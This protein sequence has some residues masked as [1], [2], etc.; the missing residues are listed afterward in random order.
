MGLFGRLK[1][2]FQGKKGN[3]IFKD[4][5]DISELRKFT[6][7]ETLSKK[8]QDNIALIKEYQGNSFGLQVRE[9]QMGPKNVQGAA[10]F[11]EGMVSTNILDQV[12]HALL[13]ESAKFADLPAKGSE[14]LPFVRDKLIPAPEV[15]GVEGLNELFDKLLLG[16]T[17]FLFDGTDK[18]LTVDTKGWSTRE[19]S[20]SDAEVAIRGPREG[21]IESIHE[22]LALIRRRI[23]VPQLW[24]EDFNMGSLTRTSVALVYIKGLVGE[25]IL[26]EVRNRLNKIDTD[27]IIESGD[28]EEFIEDAPFTVFPTILRTERPDRVVGG[29]LEGQ[30]ALVVNGTPFVLLFPATFFNMLHAPDDYYEKPPAG[31]FLRILRYMAIVLSTFLPGIYVAVINF[32]PEI[33]PT[34]LFLRIAA[35]REGVP[36]PVVVEL[37]IMES[38]FEVLREAGVRLP[39]SIGPAISIVGALVLGDAAISA[40]I[41]S[42]PVV[43]VVALTA[44][45]SFA[46]PNFALGIAGRLLRFGFVFL[47]AIFGLFGIQFGILLLI[48]HVCALRSFG[49]PYLNPSAPLIW[50]DMVRDH[51]LRTW[52]WGATERPKLVGFREPQRGSSKMKD[53]HFQI[54]SRDKKQEN[55]GD[56]AGSRDKKQENAG[57]KNQAASRDKKEEVSEGK[58]GENPREKGSQTKYKKNSRG[59]KEEGTEN[60]S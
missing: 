13:I 5:A 10:V 3:P 38:V 48:I 23:R 26:E 34:T 31:T 20:E 53:E 56:K 8:L 30:A 7:K 21:F 15:G 55:T 14:M 57:D 29:L 59:K 52:T 42:P 9:F 16:D 22:N 18:A 19:I 27:K 28:I 6:E 39:A 4:G 44:I 33:L 50:K 41:V 47:G 25:G 60:E 35:T 36:F 2:L 51:L 32:H 54:F 24:V 58:N 37:L 1:K 17:I 49:I 40:G 46:T 12:M 43:I 11:I 45:A